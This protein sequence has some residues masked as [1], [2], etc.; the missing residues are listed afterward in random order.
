MATLEVHNLQDS[1]EFKAIYNYTNY[2]TAEEESSFFLIPLYLM[3]LLLLEF[4]I[5]VW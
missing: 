5:A 3:Y 1:K 4:P 2:L